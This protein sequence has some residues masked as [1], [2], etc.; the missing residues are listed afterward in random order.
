MISPIKTRNGRDKTPAMT[1]GVTKY[2]NGF[3]DKVFSASIC[4]VTLIVPISAAIAA[5]ARPAT[6]NPANT[7][8]SSL[9]IDNTTTL[10]IALSAENLEKPVYDCKARTIPVKIAVSPTTGKELKPIL[11]TWLKKSLK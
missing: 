7:G 3:V 4:S 5:P 10:G 2:E 8:A 6:I 9:V 11:K 1:L